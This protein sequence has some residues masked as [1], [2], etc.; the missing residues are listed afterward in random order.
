M[1]D[2]T[3]LPPRCVPGGTGTA[4]QPWKRQ[5]KVFRYN[6]ASAFTS[7]AEP[8]PTET[9]PG[10]QRIPAAPSPRDHTPTPLPRTLCQSDSLLHWLY[11]HALPTNYQLN[12]SSSAPYKGVGHLIITDSMRK[13]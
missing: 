12:I 3:L 2:K 7:T 11:H 8:R 1:A 10:P 13:D 9:S 5:G 4:A 6:W